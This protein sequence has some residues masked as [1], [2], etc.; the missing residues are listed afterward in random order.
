MATETTKGG[1]DGTATVTTKTGADAA[2]MADRSSA[3][4]G[5]TTREGGFGGTGYNGN[6]IVQPKPGE[7]KRKSKG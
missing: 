5:Q 7:M 1:N 6:G 3:P 2:A 4:A